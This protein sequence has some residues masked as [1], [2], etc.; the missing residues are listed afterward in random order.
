MQAVIVVLREVLIGVVTLLQWHV[1]LI[2][3]CLLV[4]AHLVLRREAVVGPYAVDKH[5]A[6]LSWCL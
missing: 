2:K 5:S 1:C 6:V 4:V 3:L